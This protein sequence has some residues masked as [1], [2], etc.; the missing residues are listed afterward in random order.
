MIFFILNDDI[1]LKLHK[2]DAVLYK[3]IKKANA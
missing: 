1:M 3:K 2:W